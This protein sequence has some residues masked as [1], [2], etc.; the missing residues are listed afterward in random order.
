[1]EFIINSMAAF[2][3]TYIALVVIAVLAF[4][5]AYIS[6][7]REEKKYREWSNLDRGEPD[8]KTKEG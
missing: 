1:M 6:A 2:P 5:G 4:T 3:G 7:G 8:L